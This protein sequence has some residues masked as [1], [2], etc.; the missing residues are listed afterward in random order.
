VD[1]VAVA[2]DQVE[3]L[4]DPSRRPHAVV[5]PS[6]VVN[7]VEGRVFSRDRAAQILQQLLTMPRT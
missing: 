6:A 2:G 7:F 1:H 3:G 4:V 5:R